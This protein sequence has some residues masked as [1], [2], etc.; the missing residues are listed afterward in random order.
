[1]TAAPESL[2]SD[3]YLVNWFKRRFYRITVCRDLFGHLS[4]TRSW[5]ALDSNRGGM[6]TIV[7]E[8]AHEA[9]TVIASTLKVRT[10]RYYASRA[11]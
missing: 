2:P 4:V 5:G 1:M 11:S 3:V 8:T 10:R 6:K 7:C 9:D